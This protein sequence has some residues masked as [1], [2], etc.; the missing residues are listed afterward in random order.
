LLAALLAS[1][2]LGS[3]LYSGN[4]LEK[5][6][7]L[8][9]TQL[10]VLDCIPYYH[11]LGRLRVQLPPTY[12]VIAVYLGTEVF[13]GLFLSSAYIDCLSLTSL[14]VCPS[15]PAKCLRAVLSA[16]IEANTQINH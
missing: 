5:K 11:W 1:D 16:V 15:D 8:R 4:F 3:A 10:R 7:A 9:E 6:F 13:T 14:F 2:A 12:L